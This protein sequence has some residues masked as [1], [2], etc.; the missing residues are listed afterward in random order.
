MSTVLAYYYIVPF[1]QIAQHT[2]AHRVSGG[3][4]ERFQSPTLESATHT[5]TCTHQILPH[6]NSHFHCLCSYLDLLQW[7]QGGKARG[8]GP[9]SCK[10]SESS[11]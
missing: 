10:D 8:E 1:A 11:S 5:H 7:Y 3:E 2:P 9:D 4:I 6:T